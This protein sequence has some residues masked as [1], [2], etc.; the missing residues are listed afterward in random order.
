MSDRCPETPVAQD[1]LRPTPP[2]E[3]TPAGWYHRTHHPRPRR[4]QSDIT[5]WTFQLL[6]RH[7]PQGDQHQVVTSDGN[8]LV[9][10]RP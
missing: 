8:T 4:S 10:R 1:E 7:D 5:G 9:A 2:W 3:T 6:H